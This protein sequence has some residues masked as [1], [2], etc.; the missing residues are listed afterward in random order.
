MRTKT[1]NGKEY[2][3]TK[4]TQPE[5]VC[6]DCVFW[7]IGCIYRIDRKENPECMRFGN[8]RMIWKEVTNGDKE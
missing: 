2:E 6:L 1:I 5:K 4:T 3:L 8:Y 7:D